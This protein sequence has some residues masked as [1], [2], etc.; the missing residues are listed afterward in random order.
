MYFLINFPQCWQTNSSLVKELATYQVQYELKSN[1]EDLQ[2]KPD[3][4]ELCHKNKFIQNRICKFC[5]NHL[6][7]NCSFP[8]GAG[9]QVCNGSFLC[10]GL[11]C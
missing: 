6:C 1:V 10:Y 8:T 4:C 5:R 11:F 9:K 3:L 7:N 2:M